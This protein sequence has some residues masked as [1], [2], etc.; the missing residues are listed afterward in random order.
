MEVVKDAK[1]AAAIRGD[2][3]HSEA[4]APLERMP[5]GFDVLGQTDFTRR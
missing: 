4:L 1:A 2:I 5:G 3:D